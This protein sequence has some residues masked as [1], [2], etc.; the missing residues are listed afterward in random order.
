MVSVDSMVERIAERLRRPAGTAVFC[1]AGISFHSG[2]P[3]VHQLVPALL[4]ILNLDDMQRIALWS[5]SDGLAM[6]FEAFIETLQQYTPLEPLFEIYAAGRPN[7]THRLI[8]K[9]MRQGSV[10]T[11]CTTNFDLLIER[12]LKDEGW[13][14]GRDY[15]VLYTEDQF[16]RLEYGS[17]RPRLIK[18]HGGL[19]DPDEMAITLKQVAAETL[20]P[21]RRQVVEHL[22]AS[23]QHSSV[24]I[25]GYSSSDIFDISPLIE[26][27]EE[28]GK[29]VIYIEHSQEFRVE[30][31]RRRQTKNPFQRFETGNRFFYDTDQL[32][33][34]L[35]PAFSEKEPYELHHMSTPWRRQ[36]DRWRKQSE[37]I[38]VCE[39]REAIAGHLFLKLSNYDEAR[40]FWLRALE[41]AEA[42]G[43]AK[44]I[45]CWS[46]NVGFLLLESEEYER[47]RELFQRALELAR[48][49][50]DLV[51][52]ALQVNHLG[53]CAFALKNYESAGMHYQDAFEISQRLENP[54]WQYTHLTNLANV[55][56]AQQDLA[57]AKLRY[58]EALELAR[59]HGDLAMEGRILENLGA[60]R[61]HEAKMGKSASL[62]SAAFSVAHDLGDIR[63]AGPLLVTSAKLQTLEEFEEDFVHGDFEL[64][65]FLGSFAD[66]VVEQAP[67]GGH[68]H[69]GL[70][71]LM[72]F[73]KGMGGAMGRILSD[74]PAPAMDPQ[75]DDPFALALVWIEHKAGGELAQEKENWQK[76]A[77]HYQQAL[78]AL[79]RD[80]WSDDEELVELLR[81]FALVSRKLGRDVQARELYERALHLARRDEDESAEYSICIR[82]GELYLDLEKFPQAK[83]CFEVAGRIA[84][85]ID[86]LEA[87]GFW[88]GK[89]G[90]ACLGLDEL[91]EARQLIEQAAS[92]A[93]Q[94]NEDHLTIYW[95]GFLIKIAKNPDDDRAIQAYQDELTALARKTSSSK[96]A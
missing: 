24:L 80:D 81:N 82:L 36:V 46:G 74:D 12:A 6:P 85:S 55:A 93:R 18:I 15:D 35:W 73:L 42:A 69:E 39:F 92:V 89:K 17:T 72:P 10:Q 22:F 29:E 63:R 30:P 65:A 79:E 38:S 64:D 45:A 61:S 4:D 2:L 23:G 20:V 56:V 52:E 86:D 31:I 78:M 11:V 47:A 57:A 95:L 34:Q 16:E 66:K 28:E 67:Q 43:E 19:Q 68:L 51:L 7:T 53:A 71:M 62:Y 33:E 26:G 54:V 3:V 1:G 76:A 37:A 14:E 83:V 32:I 5:T 58:E 91:E 41:M 94:A 27:I 50:G 59:Q 40:Q 60:M 87:E 13:Q 9:W 25:L 21:G 77:D 90:L 48:A 49:E 44:A 70:S 96:G 88:L 84:V 8:A 75:E